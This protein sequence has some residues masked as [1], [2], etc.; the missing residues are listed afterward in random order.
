V[1]AAE[2]TKK[3]ERQ[4]MKNKWKLV[5]VI[6]TLGVSGLV[7]CAQD[8][9]GGP[10]GP[11]PEEAGGGGPGGPDNQSR[12]GGPPGG[13]DPAQFQQQMLEQTRKN[14]SVTNDAEWTAI[15]PL[16]QK[17][18]DA[19]REARPGGGMRMF[20]PPGG[21]NGRGGP[22]GQVSSEQQALQKAIEANAPVAEIKAALTK[23]RSAHLDKQAKLE[24][25]QNDLKNV[26]SV[27]QE[28]QAV[29]MGLLP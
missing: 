15:K 4:Y 22:E 14:L 7:A 23:C 2:L 5:L 27:K 3:D 12:A 17:V 10:G 9:N 1:A 20:G 13:F 28:A 26:L 8:D 25:A 16:V 18:M 29:L 24:S 19:R 6:L 21:P 11:P